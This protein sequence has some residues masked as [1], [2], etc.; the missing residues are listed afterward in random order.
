[1]PALPPDTVTTPA[2]IAAPAVDVPILHL[3]TVQEPAVVDVHS[4]AWSAGLVKSA[5][6]AALTKSCPAAL[7]LVDLSPT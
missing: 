1:M 2:L 6:P 7:N 4:P 5:E 3:M